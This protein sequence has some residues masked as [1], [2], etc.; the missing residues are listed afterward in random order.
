[1]TADFLRSHSSRRRGTHARQ[2]SLLARGKLRE[3]FARWQ[4][5]GIHRQ[6]TSPTATLGANVHER[7]AFRQDIL[8][9]WYREHCDPYRDA[10]LPAAPIDL[11]VLLSRRCIIAPK[12]TRLPVVA[13][14]LTFTWILNFMSAS[15][16]KSLICRRRHHHPRRPHRPPHPRRPHRPPRAFM[17]SWSAACG[18]QAYCQRRNSTVEPTMEHC[19]FLHML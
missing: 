8:R 1:M 13:G 2:L 12:P 16:D 4:S 7:M 5:A 6:G 9:T 19:C 17:R 14:S 3:L 11:L 18:R 10:S 15:Q